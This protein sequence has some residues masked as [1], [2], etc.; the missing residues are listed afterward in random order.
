LIA[1]DH[2]P[3]IEVYSPITTWYDDVPP[4]Q[5]HTIRNPKP[6][7]S[8]VDGNGHDILP[9]ISQIDRVCTEGNQHSFDT[10]IVDLGELSGVNQIKLLYNAWVDWPSGTEQ[11]IRDQY[12][13]SHPGEQA[14]YMPYVEVMNEYGEWEPVSNEEHFGTPQAAPRTMVIDITDWFKTNDYRMKIHNWQKVHI[15]YIAVDTSEDEQVLVTELSPILANFHWKGVSKQSSPDMKEP[16]IPD[17]DDVITDITGFHVWEGNFTRYGDVLPLLSNVDDK[18]VIMHVGDSISIE[19]DELAIPDGLERDYYLFSDGYYKQNFVR[20]LL[21]QDISNV[22]PLPF[23]EMSNYP[24][25][26]SESYPYDADHIAYINEYNT[27]AFG[28]SNGSGHNT[29]HTDYVKVEV[30]LK[31]AAPVVGG[32]LIGEHWIEIL[33]PWIIVAVAIIIVGNI[34]LRRRRAQS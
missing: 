15:D 27:R 31:E 17:F 23:H 32:T 8:A 34:I 24:Y 33:M 11:F 2:S 9:I 26:D 6:P 30:I 29:I 21:G 3:N 7:I 16:T 18:F 20:L 28:P 1:V 12:V 22:E 4:F 10:I 13:E 25:P 5:I 14:D 19:F